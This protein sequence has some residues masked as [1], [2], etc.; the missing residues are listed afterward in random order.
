MR[1]IP[2]ALD[3]G[4]VSVRA[5]LPSSGGRLCLRRLGDGLISRLGPGWLLLVP[6]IAGLA[7][8]EARSDPCVM[9]FEGDV[10]FGQGFTLEIE[11]GGTSPGTEHDQVVVGG[12]ATL[13]G[14]LEVTLLDD[15]RPVHNDAF[16]IMTF[17]SRA[18]TFGAYAGL[19]LGN[20]LRLD[21]IY[22]DVDLVLAAV[23]GGSGPWR[24]D[25][26]GNAS[27]PANWS[28]G[29]PNGI[30]DVATLGSVISAPRTVILDTP[31]ILGGVTFDSL[32]A[33]TL[34]GP[35]VLTLA[36]ESG[37]ATITVPGTSGGADDTISAGVSLASP[38]DIFHEGEGTLAFGG[39]FDNAAGETITKTGGGTVT[40]DGTQV[41]GPGALLEV[42]EGT[43]FLNTDAG[44][45][46]AAD[47]SISV[48]DA[49]LYLGCDQHLDTLT[50]GDGGKV[51]FAGARVVVLKHLVMDGVD[52]GGVTLTPEP[53]TI[54]L[55][56][57]GMLAALKWRPLRRGAACSRRTKRRQAR[58]C[59]WH[60]HRG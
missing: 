34:G 14:V 25:A 10:V 39:L 26:D 57:V 50:I 49:A 52:L 3:G 40:F 35:D 5:L 13:N 22:S 32:N 27:V 51:V 46:T 29:I 42:L 30:G 33:Y 56:G 7:V 17:G 16:K 55:L 24:F 1:R 43:V 45:D 19:N 54:A 18:G 23:Q 60:E 8:S 41:H 31:T 2:G 21:P 4:G 48:T 36:V 11:I 58:A 53:T 37:A 9:T 20:R 6:I 28:G 44:S 47:L 12:C 38:L 59:V 15:Y